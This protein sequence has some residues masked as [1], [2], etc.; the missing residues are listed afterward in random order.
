[1]GGA[2]GMTCAVES[3]RPIAFSSEETAKLIGVSAKTLANWRC[4]G[5]GPEYIRL[6]KSP[7]AQ[8]LY[9]YDDLE[10]WLHSLRCSPR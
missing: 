1:M 10:A 9:C 2:N 8:V 3:I 7:R 6:G 5:K 4:L